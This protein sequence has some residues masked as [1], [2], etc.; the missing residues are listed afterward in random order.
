[1]YK[2]NSLCLVP[3]YNTGCIVFA[4]CQDVTEHVQTTV[5][6]A[7]STYVLMQKKQAG[8]ERNKLYFPLSVWGYKTQ[9]KIIVNSLVLAAASL[10]SMKLYNLGRSSLLTT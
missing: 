5:C 10:G 7:K 2:C 4:D 8:Q 6:P 1:M 3:Q 9:V